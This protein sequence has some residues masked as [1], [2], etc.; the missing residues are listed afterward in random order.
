VT[1]GAYQILGT[2]VNPGTSQV[3]LYR[4]E[5][6]NP[7]RWTS[8]HQNIAD[9]HVRLVGSIDMTF[10]A[11]DVQDAEQKVCDDGI[12][13]RIINFKLRVMCGHHSRILRVTIKSNDDLR[14][15]G[16]AAFQYE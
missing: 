2:N 9:P 16:R 7:P 1:K 11:A 8:I 14:C 6:D 4:C 5:L 3:K 12:E 10:T 15:L 13:R